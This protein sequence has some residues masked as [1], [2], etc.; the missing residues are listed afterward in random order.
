VQGSPGAEFYQDLEVQPEDP[1][2]RKG[3]LPD[4][5][6]YSAFF[7]NH[8]KHETKLRALLEERGVTEVDVV[9]LATD[10][11]VKFTVL[12]ALKLGLQVGVLREGCRAVNL[13]PDD[14]DKAFDEMKAAG[15][16]VR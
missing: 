10:Y 15:A 7:D 1:V 3:E 11:C 6:S 8:H 4:V 5:D 9:G 14:G 16:M 2:V 12:D 13:Q